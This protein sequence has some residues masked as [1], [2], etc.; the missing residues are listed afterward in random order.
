VLV[1]PHVYQAVHNVGATDALMIKFPNHPYRHADPDKY[2]LPLDNDLIPY[3]FET[4]L[5]G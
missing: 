3:T 1:P 5:G 4:T 2:T